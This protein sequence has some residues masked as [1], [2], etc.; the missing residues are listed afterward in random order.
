MKGDLNYIISDDISN[1]I[2]GTFE[3]IFVEVHA[4]NITNTKLFT[5]IYGLPQE[6]VLRSV[7]FIIA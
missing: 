5:V 4:N 6:L 1:N 7:H 3:S 2:E